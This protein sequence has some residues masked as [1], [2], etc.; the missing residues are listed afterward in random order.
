MTQSFDKAFLQGLQAVQAGDY[1]QAKAYFEDAVNLNPQSEEAVYNLAKVYTLL[2]EHEQAIAN[3]HKALSINA[4]SRDTLFNLANLYKQLNDPKIAVELYTELLKIYPDDHEAFNNL[5]SALFDLAKPSLSAEA[6][7]KAIALNPHYAEAYFNLALCH[8]IMGDYKTGWQFYEWRWQRSHYAKHYLDLPYR[9]WQGEGLDGK[10]I[11]IWCEQGYGDSIQFVRFL[12]HLRRYSTKVCLLCY[13]A[14]HRLFAHSDLADEIYSDIKSIP[15]CDYHLPMMSLPLLLGIDKEEDF[16][17]EAYL[18]ANC[19]GKFADLVS[20]STQHRLKVG[21][22]WRG[23]KKH[24]NNHKRS[25][26]NDILQ[27]LIEA[28]DIAFFN[29]TKD[30]QLTLDGI[31]DLMPNCKDFYDT[32]CLIKELD[33]VISV[34]TAVAHLSGALGKQTWLLLP[35]APDWRWQL[36]KN[37]TA[38]YASMQIFRQTEIGSWQ[39]VIAQIKDRLAVMVHNA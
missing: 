19:R 37:T 22:S 38:W 4:S 15:K 39:S 33:L 28:S 27:E 23:F 1:L 17:S 29:L 20:S 9:L 13:P 10:S 11:L 14:L 2:G 6:F 8:L 21:L 16:G 32:A 12:K 36:H 30:A 34:D 31:I 3:Y 7:K 26:N 5:G 24:I 35:F 18:H 25:F